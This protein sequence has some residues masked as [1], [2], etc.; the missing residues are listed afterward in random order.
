MYF[1][2][3]HAVLNGLSV[4]HNPVKTINVTTT[5]GKQ[6]VLFDQEYGYA[7]QPG[8]VDIDAPTVIYEASPSDAL[9]R[10]TQMI[11][12]S[13]NSEW[14]RCGV[15]ITWRE[16]GVNDPE[17]GWYII[18]PQQFSEEFLFSAYAEPTISVE[19]RTRRRNSVGIFTDSKALP[20]DFNLP[21]VGLAA[22]PMGMS[23]QFPA[24]QLL[25]R[26]LVEVELHHGDLG[27]GYG[28]AN[29]P[30]GFAAMELAEPMR[31]LRQDRLQRALQA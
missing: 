12:L 25:T 6:V 23:A 17:D 4:G 9:T 7:M 15:F 19:L 2:P 3:I 21:G 1:G 31:S 29:W 16:D 22:V 10:L 18:R 28:P 13:Q 5:T 8:P 30:A 26:R 14:Q 24:A 27:T 11:E 20:N